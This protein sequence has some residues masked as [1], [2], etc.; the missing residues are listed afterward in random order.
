MGIGW[1]R[2]TVLVLAAVLLNGCVLFTGKG[3]D[4]LYRVEKGDTLYS[5]AF[6]N[7]MDFRTL[8]KWNGI[9]PPYTIYAG[10]WLRLSPSRYDSAP[11]RSTKQASSRPAAKPST[12]ARKPASSKQSAS[13][14]AKSPPAVAHP[15][16]IKTKAPRAGRWLWPANGNILRSYAPDKGR[17]GIDIAGSLGASVKASAAG[18]VVYSGGGLKGYGQLII[19]KH[20][21]TYLSA[22]GFN[23]QLLVGQGDNVKQGQQIALM[24]EGPGRKAILRFEVRKNGKTVNPATVLPKR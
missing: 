9:S 7:Q 24:G 11:S 17:T 4:D 6:R 3:Y 21:E 19:I 18:R 13:A 2:L 20:S 14:R 1:H 8:A 15:P 12:S 5:I 16:E 23:S 22:Y 10:Q